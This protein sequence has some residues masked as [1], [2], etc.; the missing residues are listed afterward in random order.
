MVVFDEVKGLL[1]SLQG[2]LLNKLLNL[3]DLLLLRRLSIQDLLVG[4][5]GGQL[6]FQMLNET[7][8][9]LQHSKLDDIVENILAVDKA[10]ELL[11]FDTD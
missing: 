4:V 11:A 2:N 1:K 3:S 8:I 7:R 10:Q 6:V 9:L 5:D